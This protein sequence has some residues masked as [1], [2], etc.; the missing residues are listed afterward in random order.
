MV[1]TKGYDIAV[2]GGG[3]AGMTA[4]YHAVR[5]GRRVLLID[6]MRPPG[7]KIPLSGG[8]RCNILPLQPIEPSAY[9]SDSS[10]NILKKI[11]LSWPLDEVRSF[12]SGPIGLKLIDKRK[13]GKVFPLFGGG[14]EVR[15]HM[16]AVVRRNGV[17]VRTGSAVV[18][19]EPSQRR[20]VVLE[21]GDSIVA[22]RVIIATGGMS[23]PQTGSDGS[24][25]AIARRL[26]HRIVDPYP[27]LVSL[28]GGSPAH[29]QLAGLS[30]PVVLSVGEG[31]ARMRVRGD[32][33][34]THRGYSGPAIL[35][36]AHVVARSVNTDE[37]PIIEVAWSDKREEEWEQILAPSGKTVRGVLKEVLP[38]RLV[39]VLLDELSLSE[40][41]TA[42]L[43]R[44]DRKRLVTALT[45]YRLPW[46]RAGG[47]NEAEVTGGGVSLSEVEPRTLRSRIVPQIYFCGEI[48]DAFGPIGGTNFLWSFVTGKLAGQGAALE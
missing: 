33:L 24:G 40:A 31:K 25:F 38:D 45:R 35:N 29:H 4:A 20:S 12:L 2:V 1:K 19:I 8:G 39:D 23:Y 15:N 10:V 37:P 7:Q 41:R 11:I 32:F 13:T 27:A 30:I 21:S 26:G 43:S 48:L 46:H 36:I 18:D 5:A 47:W 9:V 6:R 44:S 28:R 34:F 42:T 22:E 16:L 17:E 14:E 3:P